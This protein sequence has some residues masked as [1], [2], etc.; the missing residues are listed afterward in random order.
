MRNM[1]VSFVFVL[2]YCI[3]A[4]LNDA[5]GSLSKT[6]SYKSYAFIKSSAVIFGK[7]SV[8]FGKC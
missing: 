3:N 1:T 6:L 4:L 8:I 7:E 2:I 5:S